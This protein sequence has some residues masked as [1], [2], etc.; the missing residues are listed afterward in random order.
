MNLNMEDKAKKRQER[1]YILIAVS[2]FLLPVVIGLLLPFIC[3]CFVV[4]WVE[5]SINYKEEKDIDKITPKLEMI[6][7]EDYEI[8]FDTDCKVLEGRRVETVSSDKY[9][10]RFEA[11][12][13]ELEG[14][15][16]GDRWLYEK[17]EPYAEPY[18]YDGKIYDVEVDYYTLNYEVGSTSY[19][20]EIYCHEN[21][22]VQEYIVEARSVE[23]W[24]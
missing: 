11:T 20:V 12:E 1:K 8:D 3:S 21:G 6:L 14:M 18:V 24:Q 22:N 15:L 23:Y 5:L 19:S 16:L 13:E 9:F 2:Y 17:R 10:I 4:L 7:E